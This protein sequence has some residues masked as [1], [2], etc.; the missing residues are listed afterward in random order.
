[1]RGIIPSVLAGFLFAIT[2]VEVS[3]EETPA[4]FSVH[5]VF[6]DHMVLQR[7][8]PVKISGTAKP[9]EMI[10]AVLAGNSKQVAAG[11]D[12]KWEVT[13][14]PMEAGGPYEV[15]VKNSE[16]VQVQFSD[17]LVGEVW[18]CSGQS[19]M[20]MPVFSGSD[21]WNSANGEEEVKNA[22]YPEIRLYNTRRALAPKG[23]EEEPPGPGW[24]VCSP[25]TVGPFSAAGY[26]FGRRLYKDLNV[27]IG[28]V[29]SS[30]GG[31][32]IESWISEEGYRL[33][34]RTQE[35][36]K[37]SSA[38]LSAEEQKKEEKKTFAA[39]YAWKDK[40]DTFAPDKTKEAA[41]WK[42]PALDD[43][44]W[45]NAN[46]GT[47][48]TYNLDGVV[49]YRNTIDIPETWQGRELTLSL[50][51]VDDCDETFFAGEKVGF[52]DTDTREYW[53][54]KRV[55]K[56]PGNLVKA[57][58][59]TIA[60]RVTDYYESG[61]LTGPVELLKIYPTGEETS[62][63]KLSSGWK[64]KVEF[65]ADLKE[66]GQRPTVRDR[67]S[68]TPHFPS[69]L[70]NAMVAP[71]TVYPMRG[72]IWYQGESN[73]GRY[74]D[75]M[76]LHPLLAN[77][78][79]R[80]WQNP[81]F[82]F[83]FVQL[84]AYEKH[85]PKKRLA[86][87]F[88]VGSQPSDPSWAKLREVQTATLN[89]PNTGMA[90]TIDIGDHSDIHPSDKQTVGYRLAM[91]AERICYGRKEVSAGPL[92]KGMKID[93]SRIRVFFS[94]VGGG[95]VAK[96]GDLKEF[97]I[98]GEDGT[99]VWAKAV[100]DG[101]SVLVWSENVPQP[102]AVRYAWAMYPPNP[103]LYNR[104]GFAASPFRTDQPDYLLRAK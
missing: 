22:N 19:N 63:I 43:S 40:F 49:W 94:N 87:D 37:I 26:Y 16:N 62:A 35:L 7:G 79:R 78:W 31:T 36:Q 70:Y 104:E 91:E 46:A 2:C 66:L 65:A 76:M 101:D 88:W 71:W 51:K 38:R 42:E 21:F 69:T 58:K 4:S 18:M 52:T 6:G 100:I 103:N 95:L 68:N 47:P 74:E 17:V 81:E 3:S 73:A 102:K 32:P 55:Y 83:V 23:P 10:T 34:G 56:I 93:G 77:D 75:Y 5:K 96:G 9:G 11:Q 92:Y 84:A 30:W 8:K 82:A 50:G 41:D 44:D 86:D 25:E 33:A 54:H 98:A 20:S 28:L 85:T 15:T 29:N 45:D 64:T 60:I 72:F 61:G 48:F 39:F 59:A 53:A 12:G 1:M 14:P 24:A 57:G 80:L 89:L 67:G 27:P 90:V 13:L 99:F 97:S